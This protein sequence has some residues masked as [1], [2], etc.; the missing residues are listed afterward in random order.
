M[1][2]EVVLCRQLQ[3][4]VWHPSVLCGIAV[5]SKGKKRVVFC[6]IFNVMS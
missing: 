3:C 4:A 1:G 5:E 2:I 6:S